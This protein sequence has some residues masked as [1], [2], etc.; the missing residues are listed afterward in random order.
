VTALS[1]E[2]NQKTWRKTLPMCNQEPNWWDSK[3]WPLT[4]QS[5]WF[6]CMLGHAVTW[7]SYLYLVSQARLFFLWGVW[8]LFPV[9]SVAPSLP[10]NHTP[11]RKASGPR[12]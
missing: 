4:P 10:A 7:H 5:K 6:N 12:D 3:W 2:E 11:H 1:W 9:G 8:T